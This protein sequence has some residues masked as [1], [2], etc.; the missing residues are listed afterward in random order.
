MVKDIDRL[1][2]GIRERGADSLYKWPTIRSER[3]RRFQNAYLRS[4]EPEHF[5]VSATT[6]PSELQ[7]A[8][9]LCSPPALV[10]IRGAIRMPSPL[11]AGRYN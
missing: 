5:E 10:F 7:K 1:K 3:Q 4:L 2:A 11:H 8:E 6:H 9:A